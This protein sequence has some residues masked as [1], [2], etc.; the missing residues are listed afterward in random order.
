MSSA[1]DPADTFGWVQDAAAHLVAPPL[2]S[3]QI[4]GDVG[5]SCRVCVFSDG[6]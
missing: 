2:A 3:N 4:G 1:T 5:S 6:L